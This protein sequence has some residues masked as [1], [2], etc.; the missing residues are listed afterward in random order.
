MRCK[1]PDAFALPV[2]VLALLATQYI[3]AFPAAW[4]FDRIHST[5][6]MSRDIVDSTCGINANWI[7][8]VIAAWIPDVGF[9]ATNGIVWKNGRHPRYRMSR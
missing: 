4:Q 2:I 3:P 6:I 9:A 5:L 1:N 8:S 7:K